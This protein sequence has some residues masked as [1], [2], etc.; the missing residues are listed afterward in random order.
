MVMVD[1]S[2]FFA[3][4]LASIRAKSH[5]HKKA[6]C[7]GAASVFLTQTDLRYRNKMHRKKK[8]RGILM[9]LLL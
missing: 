9:L 2:S 7:Y 1:S 6:G 5:G 8:F 4:A 3:S